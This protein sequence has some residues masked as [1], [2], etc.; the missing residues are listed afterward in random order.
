M[1]VYINL[2]GM[3]LSVDPGGVTMSEWAIE[4]FD[5]VKKFPRQIGRASCRER[6]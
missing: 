1:N 6:V 5:L 3:P 2:D 4:A